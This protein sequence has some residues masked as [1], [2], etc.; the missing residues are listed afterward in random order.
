MQH[1]SLQVLGLHPVAVCCPT[2]FRL[3]AHPHTQRFRGHAATAPE[4]SW[5]HF[6]QALCS[7][8]ALIVSFQSHKHHISGQ[9][10]S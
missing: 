6:G 10:N 8:I 2:R 5:E 4:T 7:V 1:T 3:A 9:M